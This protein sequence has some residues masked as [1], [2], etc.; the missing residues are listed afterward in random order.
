LLA[1]FL[2]RVSIPFV[3][4][5]EHSPFDGEG[6]PTQDE[7]QSPSFRGGSTPVYYTTA[8]TPAVGVSIPFVSGREHSLT[9]TSNSTPR[10]CSWRFNPLRF[11]AG[12][13]RTHKCTDLGCIPEFQS[14]SFR[15]G[16][17]PGEIEEFDDELST[18][19]QSPS[20]RGGS[21]P[22]LGLGL[23]RYKRSFTPLRFGA[24]ALHYAFWRS[25]HQQGVSIP[26]VS[27]REHSSV[28]K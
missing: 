18:K 25:N 5:R 17:T 21:T 3:S 6:S 7:F 15:G 16:S 4:G 12:A 13:L 19:F 23:T 14:P 10:P 8:A 27:G 22:L 2:V 28:Q 26:F 24:G 20:F 11:G 1:G 9:R